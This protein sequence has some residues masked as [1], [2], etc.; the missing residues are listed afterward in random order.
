MIISLK[1]ARFCIT[2]GLKLNYF[3]A[4][5]NNN[6]VYVY[7]AEVSNSACVYLKKG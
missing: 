5:E 2:K 1:T 7:K 6:S 4:N 3:V